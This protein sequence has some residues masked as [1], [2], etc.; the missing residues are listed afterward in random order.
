MPSDVRYLALDSVARTLIYESSAV[1]VGP[2]VTVAGSAADPQ[3][4]TLDPDVQQ[5]IHRVMHALRRFAIAYAE[6]GAEA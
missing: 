4:G 5:R 3:S 6:L 1:Q 2:A